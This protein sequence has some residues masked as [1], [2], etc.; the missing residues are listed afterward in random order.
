M[1]DL[2]ELNE[3]YNQEI[4]SKN[5]FIITTEL[6]T[7]YNGNQEVLQEMHFSKEDLQDPKTIKKI[8]EKLEKKQPVFSTIGALSGFLAFVLSMIGL[9][10][11]GGEAVFI[12]IL[13]FPFIAGFCITI[14]LYIAAIPRKQFEK[15]YK[16]FKTKVEK[17]K[18][19]C[20]KKLETEEDS[21]KKTEYKNIIKNCD[22]VLKAIEKR[23]KELAD[24][25]FQEEVKEMILLYKRALTLYTTP[26]K[27][28]TFYEYYDIADLF[29]ILSKLGITQNDFMKHCKSINWKLS[30]NLYLPLEDYFKKHVATQKQWDKYS[31]QLKSLSIIPEYKTNSPVKIFFTTGS[32]EEIIYSPKNNKFYVLETVDVFFNSYYKGDMVVKETNLFDYFKNYNDDF[33][34]E[35]LIEA[36]KELGYYILS[37]CPPGLIKEKLPK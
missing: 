26:E 30:E 24:K 9:A 28:Y 36:D 8:E 15:D 21:K 17:L 34:E 6:N 27:M 33:N 32:G 22:K 35:A 29:H 11:L 3:V 23:E 31:N 25:K 5:D 14:G 18:D 7:Y 37:E 13:G 19:N 12:V 4:K 2:K 1:I 16:K 20:Q 10:I